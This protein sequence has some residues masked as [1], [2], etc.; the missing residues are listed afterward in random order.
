MRVVAARFA[1][2]RQASAVLEMLQ[3]ELRVDPPDVAV[4]P[5]GSPGQPPGDDFVLA[6][7]FPDDRAEDVVKLVSREGGQIVANIDERWTRPRRAAPPSQGW[8]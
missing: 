8:A 1:G 5:L 7:R 3:L 6:G 4:A 2:P